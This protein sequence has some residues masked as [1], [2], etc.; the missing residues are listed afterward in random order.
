MQEG[1]MRVLD[2]IVNAHDGASGSPGGGIAAMLTPL[3]DQN[4][5]GSIMDDVTSLIGRF[6][7]RP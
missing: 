5:D 4:R 3:L 2:A 1:H 6:M 7:K